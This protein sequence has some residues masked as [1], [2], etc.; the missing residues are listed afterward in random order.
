MTRLYLFTLFNVKVVVCEIISTI[1]KIYRSFLQIY[2]RFSKYID[3]STE[4][5]DLPT[6]NDT[7]RGMQR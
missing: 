1:F 3:G 7:K 2:Q 6:N 4:N 5:I